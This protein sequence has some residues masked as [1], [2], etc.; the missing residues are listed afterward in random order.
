VCRTVRPD[1]ETVLHDVDESLRTF[2]RTRCRI[3]NDIEVVFD[4]PRKDWSSRRSTPAIDVFLYDIRENLDRR[5]AL[6][7]D[8]RGSD[9]LVDRRVPPTRWFNL[10]YLVTAW[11]QRSEDE[12]RLLSSVLFGFL[13]VHSLPPEVLAGSLAGMERQI[14]LTIGRPP[15]QDRSISDIWSALGGELRPSLDLVVVVPFE[16][17]HGFAFGPPVFEAPAVNVRRPGGTTESAPKKKGAADPGRSSGHRRAKA[18]PVGTVAPETVGRSLLDRR[19]AALAREEAVGGTNDLPGR[20]FRFAVHEGKVPPTPAG[21][22]DDH[23]ADDQRADDQRADGR[24]ADGPQGQGGGAG[25]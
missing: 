16:P 11:T 20:R 14:F 3:T 4:A 23:S 25:T 19:A 1:N 7:E 22:A 8:S 5:Q 9:G 24:D 18:T 2:F 17:T 13:E 15:G 6:L 21:A 12:H 10:S